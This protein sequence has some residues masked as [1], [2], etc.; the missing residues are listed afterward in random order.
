MRPSAGRSGPEIGPDQRKQWI[1]QPRLRAELQETQRAADARR[2]WRVTAVAVAVRG[3]RRWRVPRARATRTPWATARAAPCGELRKVC[4]R[5]GWRSAGGAHPDS[6]S[7]SAER[8]CDSNPRRDSPHI[9]H[10]NSCVYRSKR[11]KVVAGQHCCL[12]L[13]VFDATPGNVCRR[14]VEVKCSNQF[15]R[16][17]RWDTVMSWQASRSCSRS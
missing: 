16:A 15:R 3:R 6:E 4:V 11:A 14:C 12:L 17:S 5:G 7:S 9:L 2:R 13:S 1:I 10:V 8:H